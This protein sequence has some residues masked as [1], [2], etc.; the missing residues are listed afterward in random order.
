MPAGRK[1][2]GWQSRYPMFP[3]ADGRWLAVWAEAARTAVVAERLFLSK[4]ILRQDCRMSDISG[5]IIG[6]ASVVFNRRVGS[7]S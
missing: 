2:L 5:G 7:L 3:V 6:L 1:R 4:K